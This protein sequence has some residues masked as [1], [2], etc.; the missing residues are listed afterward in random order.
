MTSWFLQLISGEHLTVLA[1]EAVEAAIKQKRPVL[2]F[3][4]MASVSSLHRILNVIQHN[5]Q[6]Y[7]ADWVL[8]LGTVID[9]KS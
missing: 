2:L 6:L 7:D 3:C 5:T 9:G 1:M 8:A 4:L